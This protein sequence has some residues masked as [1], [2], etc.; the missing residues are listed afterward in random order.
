VDGTLRLLP[1]RQIGSTVLDNTLTDLD[2][3]PDGLATTNGWG[4]VA[5]PTVGRA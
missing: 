1:A 2:R 4:I 3:G 5:T